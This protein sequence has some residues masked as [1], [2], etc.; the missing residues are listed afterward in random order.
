VVGSNIANILLIL[1]LA[2][3]VMPITVDQRA[4]KR[5]GA[6]LVVATGLCLGL[7]FAEFLNRLAGAGLIALLLGYVVFTY[8]QERRGEDASARM[9]AAEASSVLR[10]AGRLWLSLALAA[11]GLLFTLAGAN[12][13]VGAAVGLARDWGVS[14]TVIGLTIVAVGTSLPELVT[15]LTA[16][17]KRQGDVALGNIVGSNI[18]NVLGILGVTALAHPIAVPEDLALMDLGVMAAASLAFI[19]FASTGRGLSR[20]EGGIF[21]L[22]YA[23]YCAVLMGAK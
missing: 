17:L 10:P 7:I 11:L 12:W 16:A 15:S 3:L 6:M 22:S 1:G 18:Y 23:G 13:L 19:V 4:F 14:E 21:L 8:L 20:L 9:H 5:D 2:A